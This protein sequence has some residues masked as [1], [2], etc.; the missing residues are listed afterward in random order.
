MEHDPAMQNMVDRTA[1]K[2]DGSDR[3][4]A[5]SLLSEGLLILV[6]AGLVPVGGAFGQELPIESWDT[7]KAEADGKG[8][9]LRFPTPL[10]EPFDPQRRAA[11]PLSAERF[12]WALNPGAPD[13]HGALLDLRIPESDAF[14]DTEFR[15]HGP[16][17]TSKSP[18]AVR[19]APL[20]HDADATLWQRLRDFKTR[21]G[22]RLLTLWNSSWSTLSLQTG[23]RGGPSLQ[24]TSRSMNRDG[25]KSG[26]FDRLFPVTIA[27]E[28]SHS[29]LFGARGA[30]PTERLRE[31]LPDPGAP[32]R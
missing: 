30:R 26:L 6:V 31:L 8:G 14:S 3:A 20:G 24:W 11:G 25:A 9:R 28:P 17:V 18:A 23:K 29:Q 7:S 22:V 32:A 27:G 21:D 2:R 15:P 4:G 12:D 13:A 10:D 16:S 1:F 19:G 5:S